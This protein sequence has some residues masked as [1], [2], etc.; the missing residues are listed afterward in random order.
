MNEWYSSKGLTVGLVL[1]LACRCPTFSASS[2]SS[3]M[4]SVISG[5]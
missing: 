3:E 1:V 2:L 5:V 4:Y